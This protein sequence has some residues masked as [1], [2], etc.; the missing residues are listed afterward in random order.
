MTLAT[1]TD[2]P[3]PVLDRFA[4]TTADGGPTT[5][6]ESVRS[7][8]VE[9]AWLPY[10]G[11][12]ALIFARRCDAKLATLKDGQQSI[13]VHITKWGEAMGCYPE[14]VVA[15]KNRLMRFGLAVWEPKGNMLGLLRHW[16]PVPPAITTPEHR[17]LL[18]AVPDIAPAEL[19]GPPC[20]DD[21]R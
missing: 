1:I 17:Q 9:E 11:P 20:L 13:T 7:A 3:A 21:D 18:L 8:Y 15:A 16:P 14:E 4:V 5:M 10:L 6:S 19:V 2:Q 12:T